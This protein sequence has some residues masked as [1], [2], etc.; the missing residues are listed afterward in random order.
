[1][2]KQIIAMG[3][4]ALMAL[5]MAGCGGQAAQSSTAAGSGH[6]AAQSVELSL[7]HMGS[8]T[9]MA[10]QWALLFKQK[11]EAESNGN[12]KVNIF[13][14][15]EM[16][17]DAET[18]ESVLD[19]TIQMTVMQ[20]SP[21]VAFVPEMGVFDL[22]CAFATSTAEEINDVL[23]NSEFK[24]KVDTYFANA[25]LKCLGFTQG[26]T[27]RE[28]SS[29]KKVESLEDFKGLNMRVMDNLY[30]IQFWS[31][32]GCNTT[33]IPGSELYMS[34]QN[35]LVDSQENA[36]DTIVAAGMNEVQ[37]YVTMTNHTLYTN[38]MIM[39][40]SYFNSLPTEYQQVLNNVMQ[41][42]EKEMIVAYAEADKTAYD[43]LVAD[44]MEINALTDEQ[45]KQMRE[46]AE[47]VYTSVREKIGDEPV[48][49]LLS[50]V[51]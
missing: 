10:G 1:M 14:N 23:N 25:G 26:A 44:G 28:F 31:A 47:P 16:G 30:Q 15:G 13:A 50:V 38:M 45:Y 3:M 8:E 49:A 39:S 51:K 7:A 43:T 12:I 36:L 22:P 42:T 6:G 11:V 18:I 33:P 19:N 34:L 46:L 37:K 17:S 32:M 29:N 5:S 9:G 48:D 24:T 20:P 21:V 4:A 2:K 35:G 41:E 27:F 40:D